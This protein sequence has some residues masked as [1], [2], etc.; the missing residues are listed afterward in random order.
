MESVLI[1]YLGDSGGSGG[2]DGGDRLLGPEPSSGSSFLWTRPN[3][4]EDMLLFIFQPSLTIE[5][6]LSSF[7]L[8]FMLFGETFRYLFSKLE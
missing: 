4:S 3:S 8:L 6:Y 2:V 1:L 7:V 5:L